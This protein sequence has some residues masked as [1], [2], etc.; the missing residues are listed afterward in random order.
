MGTLQ[1]KVAIVTGGGRDIGRA[2]SLKLAQE[3]AAVAVNYRSSETAAQQV[4]QEIEG[5]GGKAMA[6]RADVTRMAE[7]ER[8]VQETQSAFGDSI[9]VLVNNAG[10]LVARKRMHEM[11]EAF[12]DTVLGLN[13]KSMFLVTKAV[14]PHMPDGSAIVN[15][16]SLA[17]RD[18]GGGGAIAYATSKGGVL[19]FT[20][21]LA[22]EL[23]DRKIRVNCVS[24]GLIGTTFHDTFTPDEVR[25][26]VAQMTLCGREGTPEDVAK[27]VW[28]LASDASSYINGESIEVNGGLYFI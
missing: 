10:G 1:N 24:P 18:G 22:K 11:D 17:A 9:H 13:L 2:V 14:L 8:M 4:V 5:L 16:G 6:V 28:F 23:R 26:K 15:M 20:R 21:G 12:W 19:T 3:G 25:A 27:V 7:I